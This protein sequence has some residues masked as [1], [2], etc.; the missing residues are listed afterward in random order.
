MYLVYIIH[1]LVLATY[2]LILPYILVVLAKMDLF[3][4]TYYYVIAIYGLLSHTY[5]G[6]SSGITRFYGA[7]VHCMTCTINCYVTVH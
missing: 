4:R 6:P 5:A 7:L 1:I 2:G 3:Y